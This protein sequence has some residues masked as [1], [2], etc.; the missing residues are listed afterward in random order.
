MSFEPAH[1][2]MVAECPHCRK[3]VI[4]GEERTVSK[5]SF[6]IP[7]MPTLLVVLMAICAVLVYISKLHL[8]SSQTHIIAQQSVKDPSIVNPYSYLGRFHLDRNMVAVAIWNLIGLGYL[9][10]SISK[11]SISALIGG[12]LIIGAAWAFKSWLVTSA[13]CLAVMAIVYLLASED[14]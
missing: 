6:R 7:V 1:L 11:Q 10:Y 5:S 4:L 9:R 14:N 12:I 8:E 3:K 2:G 13:C